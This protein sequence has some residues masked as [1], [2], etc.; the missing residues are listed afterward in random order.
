[1][2]VSKCASRD[3]SSTTHL[4]AAWLLVAWE[5]KNNTRVSRQTTEK[6]KLNTRLVVFRGARSE[7]PKGTIFCLLAI[8]VK[9]CSKEQVYDGFCCTT[10]YSET[11][12]R[13]GGFWI[14]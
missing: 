5:E 9:K 14:L 8:R 11:L 3:H 2:A 1:M 6:N 12:Q 7:N 4:I 10:L 13:I